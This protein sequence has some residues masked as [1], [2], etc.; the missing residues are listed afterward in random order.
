MILAP[1][2]C[3]PFPLPQNDASATTD[4]TVKYCEYIYEQIIRDK[5]YIQNFNY[6]LQFCVVKLSSFITLHATQI[7]SDHSTVDISVQMQNAFATRLQHVLVFC[8]F[9]DKLI[10]KYPGLTSILPILFGPR[11]PKGCNALLLFS[12][13]SGNHTKFVNL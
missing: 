6:W 11:G 8:D 5:V 4:F 3:I 12:S 2:S 13:V 1:M 10:R 9:S 7:L